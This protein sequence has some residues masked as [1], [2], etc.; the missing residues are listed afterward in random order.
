MRILILH[1]RYR[2][3]ALS[4]ENRVVVEEADLLRSAGHD[5][6]VLAPSPDD[7]SRAALAARSLASVGIGAVVADRV[8]SRKIEIVHCHNVYP[9]L[10][11]GV[12]TAAAKG[13]AA[14][15]VTLHNYRSMCLAGTFFRDGHVCQDCLGR[16]PWPGVVHACYRGSRSQSAVLAAS[17]VAARAMQT[18]DSVHRF[19]AVSAFIRKKHI[20]A[21]FPADRILV[22]PNVVA[23]QTLRE[24]PGTYFLL[25]SRLVVEKGISDI[26]RAWDEDLGELRIAGD[27]PERVHLE[28][29]AM[30]RGVR[31]EGAVSPEVI[32]ALLAGA[33]ALLLPSL[34]FEGQ[35][36]VV[37]E[38]YA[39][40]V[41]VVATRI[42]GLAEVVI[43]G[44][45]GITVPLGDS[46]GW[47]TA[48]KRLKEDGLSVRLGEAA[49]R[50]WMERFS[51]ERGLTMLE[52]AYGE[53][54]EERVRSSE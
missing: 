44:E 45:T 31:L 43:D 53:A 39:A 32:P 18:L 6:D 51:P 9:A 2:S 47:R 19:L 21:G 15:V 4:G 50:I 27:G 48:A 42:G 30:G 7:S 41:P 40:G 17:L 12:F 29:L 3:G 49:H 37:V 25:L 8:R 14:V 28:R 1:S 16:L 22:K 38:A 13:G 26:V 33:R 52:A 34:W 10:G 20:E 24:G 54:L 23:A 36:R 35:P 5:V 46:E 11:A